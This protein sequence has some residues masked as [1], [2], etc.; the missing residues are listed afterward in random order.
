MQ[1]QLK[2]Q[3]IPRL[4]SDFWNNAV[5]IPLSGGA[6]KMYLAVKRLLA[7]IVLFPLDFMIWFSGIGAICI[8]WA[9]KTLGRSDK[10]RLTF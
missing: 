3:K 2:G 9:E 4:D 7:R 1:S 10:N 8:T 6:M 5:P